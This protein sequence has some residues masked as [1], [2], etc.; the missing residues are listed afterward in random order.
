MAA[1]RGHIVGIINND[2]IDATNIYLADELKDYV[3]NEP[4]ALANKTWYDILNDKATWTKERLLTFQNAVQFGEHE[5]HCMKPNFK[6]I[7][8]VPKY[9]K[10]PNFYAYVPPAPDCQ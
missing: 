10:Y 9:V 7:E 4:P 2:P 6:H 8:G 3:V 1:I 5:N